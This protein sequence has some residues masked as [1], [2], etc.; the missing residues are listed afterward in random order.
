MDGSFILAMLLREQRG[1]AARAHWGEW[2][3]DGDD[4]VGPPLLFAE[5]TSVLRENVHFG[6][7]SPTDG[8]EAFLEFRLL[9]IRQVDPPGLQVQAWDLAKRYNRPR[10]YDAQYLAVAR[11]LDCELWTADARLA[12]AVQEPWLRVLA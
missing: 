10:A 8:E 6:R 11:H 7:V 5:V 4:A 2:L 1:A 12:N 3:Q 9:G